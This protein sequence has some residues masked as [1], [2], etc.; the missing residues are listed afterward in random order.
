M[1]KTNKSDVGY[2]IEIWVQTVSFS[3]GWPWKRSINTC[4]VQGCRRKGRVVAVPTTRAV[5]KLRDDSSYQARP[6]INYRI[7][8]LDWAVNC[9]MHLI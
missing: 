7:T 3:R 5:I 6:V 4:P 1:S 9:Q 8:H 2:M